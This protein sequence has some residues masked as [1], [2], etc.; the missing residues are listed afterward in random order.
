MISVL[1]QGLSIGTN[2]G[3]AHRKAHTVVLRQQA[4]ARAIAPIHKAL[5]LFYFLQISDEHADAPDN[6]LNS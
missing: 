5:G 2:D 4:V 3:V 6:L 1:K